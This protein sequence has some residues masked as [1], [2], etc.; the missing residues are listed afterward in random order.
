MVESVPI[1]ISPSTTN[2]LLLMVVASGLNGFL[3]E[4]SS[5]I[6]KA[7]QNHI[8]IFIRLKSNVI[9]NKWKCCG[10]NRKLIAINHPI[11]CCKISRIGILPTR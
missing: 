9:V 10:K 3:H 8:T 7:E 2:M 5:R 4:K 6:I 1:L 11:F